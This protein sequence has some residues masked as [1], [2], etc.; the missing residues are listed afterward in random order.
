MDQYADKLTEGTKALLQKY[1]DTFYINVY[2]TRRT[3]AMPQWAYDETY[4]NALRTY[5]AENGTDIEDVYGGV[6]FPIP[7][8]G[9]EAIWNHQLRFRPSCWHFETDALL[10]TAA[11]KLVHLNTSDAFKMMP[12]FIEGKTLEDYE[13]EWKGEFWFLRLTNTAP[14]VQADTAI[15]ARENLRGDDTISYLYLSGQRRVRRLPISCCDV[16]SAPTAGMSTFDE[17]GVFIGA[18]AMA[19]HDWK[20][21]GK[22]EMYIPYNC[23]GFNDVPLYEAITAR[24]LSPEAVRYELHRVWVVEANLKDGKRHQC[25]RQVYYLDED[26]WTA[27]LSDRYDANGDLWRCGYGLPMVLPDVPCVTAPPWGLNDLQANVLVAIDNYNDKDEQLR[28]VD[29]PL[30]NKEFTPA[31][32]Q[33]ESIR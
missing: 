28:V 30:G 3:A 9:I 14:P 26:S 1:P 12:V 19:L 29:P 10:G 32:L 25:P 6:P 7:K 31:A 20:L 22:K 18:M 27:V 11:G 24:H 8:S 5:I 4:K 13:N 16:P 2:Q 15:I 33:G 17:T 23:N 21:V